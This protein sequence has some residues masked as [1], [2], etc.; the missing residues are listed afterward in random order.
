MIGSLKQVA[1]ALRSRAV[2]FSI[3]IVQIVVGMVVVS[4]VVVLIDLFLEQHR[5]T[6][7]DMDGSFSITSEDDDVSLPTEDLRVLASLSGVRH[8]AWVASGPIHSRRLPD[9]VEAAGRSA[10]A[11]EVYGTSDAPAALGFEV[12]KGRALVPA[13][14]GALAPR[15]ILITAALARVLFESGE[16]IDRTIASHGVVAAYRVVG[17]LREASIVPPFA[18]FAG[19]VLVAPGRPVEARHAEYVVNVD[20]AHRLAFAS[21]VEAGLRARAPRRFLRIETLQASQERT[22]QGRSGSMIIFG[23]IAALVLGVVLLGS[24]GMSA[25]LVAERLREIGIRRALGARRR[26]IGAYFLFENFAVTS[27][28]VL[29]GAVLSVVAT[30]R[31]AQRAIP[32]AVLDFRHLFLSIILFWVTGLLAASMPALRASR[33]PPSVASKTV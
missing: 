2:A 20:A 29:A 30:Q 27:L 24:T 1:G 4:H 15:P 8:A 12:V 22:Y 28:G 3:L 32:F 10:Q 5:L 19:N 31:L 33:V 13:D 11:W 21:A 14:E 7:A 6:G 17:V 23:S 18:D 16:P 26:D 25:F 9:T